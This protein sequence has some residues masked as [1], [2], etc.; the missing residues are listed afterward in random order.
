[1]APDGIATATAAE[2]MQVWFGESALDNSVD[3]WS[4][5][6]RRVGMPDDIAKMVLFLASDESAYCTGA[7]FV[8]DGGMSA[9][10]RFKPASARVQ[11]REALL[12]EGPTATAPTN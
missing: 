10:H 2:A 5:L 11:H 3:G 1:M 9:D 7:Q 8:V 12:S 4:L 6:L